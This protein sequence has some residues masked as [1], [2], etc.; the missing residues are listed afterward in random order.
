MKYEI[1]NRWS[2]NYYPPS[3]SSSKRCGSS[4]KFQKSAVFLAKKHQIS[5]LWMKELDIFINENK[6]LQGIILLKK[7]LETAKKGDGEEK[8]AGRSIY[9][10]GG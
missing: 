5:S 8:F 1:E 10:K 7:W 9:I 4:S 6:D 3:G 2:K